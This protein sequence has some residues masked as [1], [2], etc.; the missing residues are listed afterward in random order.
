MSQRLKIMLGLLGAL[1]AFLIYQQLRPEPEPL[2]GPAAAPGRSAARAAGRARGGGGD[3]PSELAR[4]KMDELEPQGAIYRPGRNP[5][6]FYTPPPPQPKGPT[7]EELAEARRRAEEEA[8]LR[9]ERE[10]A[11]AAARA[12]AP[13]PKP[14][15]PAIDFAYVGSFGPDRRRVAVLLKSDDTIVNALEGDVIDGKFRLVSIGYESVGIEFVGFPDEPP[16][17]LPV[18]EEGI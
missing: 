11:A 12:A 13:P 14:R 15:P 6:D 17:Q 3:T 9:R 18:G 7:P 4:L 5:F 16:A 1:A 8:R 10:A 2:A